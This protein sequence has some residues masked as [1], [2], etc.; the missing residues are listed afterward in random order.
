MGD[1]RRMVSEVYSVEQL[2]T[3]LGC[4]RKSIYAAAERGEIP[5][6]RL[7][8]RRLFPRA[9]VDAWLRGEAAAATPETTSSTR[10][11]AGH[12]RARIDRPRRTVGK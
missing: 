6:R 11:P 7:G 8:R 2:A 1:W 5:C 9:W 10:A 4:D 12:T 3:M